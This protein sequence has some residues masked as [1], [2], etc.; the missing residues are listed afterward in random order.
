M[1]WGGKEGHGTW[2]MDKIVTVK[3][4]Y[5]QASKWKPLSRSGG[6]GESGGKKMAEKRLRIKKGTSSSSFYSNQE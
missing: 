2:V 1:G 3:W 6:D 4:S 5:M